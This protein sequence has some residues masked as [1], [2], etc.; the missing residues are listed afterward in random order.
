[1]INRRTFV[2]LASAAVMTPAIAFAEAPK[3]R[4][5]TLGKLGP[6]NDGE[7]RVRIW[8]PP[9]YE[10]SGR[11]YRTLYML[12]GQFVFSSD[13]DG[14]N[15]GADSVQYPAERTLAGALPILGTLP[16]STTGLLVLSRTRRSCGGVSWRKM[17][18]FVLVE[19]GPW[20]TTICE[21]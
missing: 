9:G 13:S 21:S 20:N 5:E 16:G 12:D 18:T 17:S 2:A 19:G 14:E 3:G 7:P 1:M 8:L 11:S 10:N 4:I 15:F 6:R